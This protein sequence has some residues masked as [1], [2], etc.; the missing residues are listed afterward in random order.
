MTF[1][2]SRTYPLEVLRIH[3]ASDLI[4]KSFG[5][6]KDLLDMRRMPVSSEENFEGKLFVQIKIA[7]DSRCYFY[8]SILA[9]F[10]PFMIHLLHHLLHHLIKKL[11]NFTIIYDT[12]VIL[13][14]SLNSA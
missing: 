5:N 4:E 12:F 2:I 9:I 6:L 1:S 11:H 7:P 10:V 14:R 3:P 13:I 8:V